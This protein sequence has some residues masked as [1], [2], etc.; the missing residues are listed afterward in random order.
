MTSFVSL[1]RHLLFLCFPNHAVH[2]IDHSATF[3]D[4]S[5]ENIRNAQIDRL[6]KLPILLRVSSSKSKKYPHSPLVLHDR[7]HLFFLHIH[8]P[9]LQWIIIYL[10]VNKTY[11]KYHLAL[12]SLLGIFLLYISSH[13]FNII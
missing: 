3:K 12:N 8:S 6:L 4:I 9:C 10:S 1:I 5:L 2:A 7:V 13:F 11:Y